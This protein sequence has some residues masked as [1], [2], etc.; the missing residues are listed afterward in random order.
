MV[1]APC[2][3]DPKKDETA[4]QSIM[5]DHFYLATHTNTSSFC[6]VKRKLDLMPRERD[7]IDNARVKNKPHAK[8]KIV[9]ERVKGSK[10]VD[11]PRYDTSL[12]QLTKKF[13][14][15]LSN[16]K[17]GVINLNTACT[18]LSVPKRRLYDITNVLEGAGLIAKTSRNN[19]KWMGRGSSRVS[20]ELEREIDLLEAKENKLDELIYYMKSQ[21]NSVLEEDAKYPF[22]F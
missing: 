3:Y 12:G 13:L 17:D 16:A 10:S 20:Y 19:I 18:V 6:Q 14:S 7:C 8:K 2:L 1:P 4:Q 21:V 5:M 9:P 22:F 11:R 15:L